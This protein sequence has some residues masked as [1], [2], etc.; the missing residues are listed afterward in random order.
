MDLRSTGNYFN[1][2]GE[3]AYSFGD[4]GSPAK[5]KKMKEK[6]LFCLIFFKFLLL[7]GEYPP[8]DPLVNCKCINFHI[9][10]TSEKKIGVKHM[11][12]MFCC[13]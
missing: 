13:C 5:N 9:T 11:A 8:P 12:I 10:C 3:Q 1:G 6:P 2:N 7:K 4:L